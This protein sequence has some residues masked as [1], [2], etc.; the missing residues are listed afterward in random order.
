MKAKKI[1]KKVV[2]HREWTDA[3]DTSSMTDKSTIILKLIVL[4]KCQ[5]NRLSFVLRTFYTHFCLKQILIRRAFTQVDIH[6]AT[7]PE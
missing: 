5:I 4:K 2:V 3:V 1:V 7:N 6:T